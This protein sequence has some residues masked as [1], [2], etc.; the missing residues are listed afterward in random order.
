MGTKI[1]IPKEH[2]ASAVLYASFLA[3]LA[4]ARQFNVPVFLLLVSFS[5]FYLAHEPIS[6]LIQFSGRPAAPGRRTWW[7]RWL[8]VDLAAGIFTGG[9]L[10][11]YGLWHLLP[12]GA[13][14]AILMAARLR[15]LAKGQ[16][17]TLAG[18][19]LSLVGLTLPAPAA[20][21]VSRGEFGATASLLW[22]VCFLFFGSGVFH[23]R[24]LLGRVKRGQPA[25]RRLR[26]AMAYHI[27]LA[28]TLVALVATGTLSGFVS[29]AFAPLIVRAFRGMAYPSGV[30]N[31]KRTGLIEMAYSILLIVLLALGW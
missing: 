10:L 2:G 24:M 22:L 28:A 6:R 5:A 19:G 1:P 31:L 13:L 21:Y 3:G 20:Y 16:E 12:L 27:L 18:E 25:G 11:A 4:A 7:R 8:V 26:Q 29:L 23:V 9:L 30:L 15:L 14:G 17:M